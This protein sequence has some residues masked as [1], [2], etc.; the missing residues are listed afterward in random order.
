MSLFILYC[1]LFALTLQ[2]KQND[3]MKRMA[4]FFGRIVH[5]RLLKYSV[6][7]VFA[8]AF[9]GFID[10]NSI[11]QHVLN[12]QKISELNSEIV[13]YNDIHKQNE[14]RLEE[15]AR[16]PKAIEKIARERYFMKADD[17]DIFV[18]YDDIER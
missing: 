12:Q 18:F 14:M 3:V 1:L 10:E 2:P 5:S 4:D 11:Y 7:V 8:V 6:V 9:I 17:E 15:L 16:D 13:K